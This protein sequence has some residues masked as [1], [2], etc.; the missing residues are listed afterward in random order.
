MNWYEYQELVADI[1]RGIG[2]KVNTNYKAVGARG[3]HA[4]DVWVKMEKFGIEMTWICE[5]K[6]WK[7]SIPKE[8]VLT[9]YEITK[10]LGVDK[11]FLFSESGFQ[12]GAIRCTKNTNITLTNVDEI[13]ELIQQELE[14]VRLIDFLKRIENLK[15]TLK[16]SWIDDLG[17]PIANNN[18]N[19]DKCLTIDGT[20]MFMIL[21]VQKALN[22]DFPVYLTKYSTEGC[23][24]EN[25][26]EL[27][28]TLSEELKI[29][30]TIV[31][32]IDNQT[33]K[34][35]IEVSNNI[36][37]F[38]QA[39]KNLLKSSEIQLFDKS[40]DIDNQSMETLKYM[41]AIA[42]SADDLKRTSKGAIA[43]EIH[44]MMRL[45][46]EYIYPHLTKVEM[47][48]NEWNDSK[49]RILNQLDILCSIS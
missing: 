38:I 5:C 11:G 40:I 26:V 41:K 1:F 37:I 36:N 44:N 47:N 20:L 18:T 13:K 35:A 33:Q 22:N 49:E 4:I 46:I 32:E 29:V 9:L 25:V 24:C 15:K 6:Y 3:E 23:K 10:D 19:F 43:R 2:A 42:K 45:L 17:Y 16:N 8:K 27:N 21:Q 14:E 12:S 31:K 39:I 28:K 7:D 30:E 48:K 34:T